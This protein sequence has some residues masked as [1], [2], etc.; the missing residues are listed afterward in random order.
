MYEVISRFQRYYIGYDTEIEKER[1]CAEAKRHLYVVG[2]ESDE[3]NRYPDP[4][5]FQSV[6]SVTIEL[7]TDLNSYKTVKKIVSN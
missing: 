5:K 7:L 6:S 4:N 2:F 3:A 1:C